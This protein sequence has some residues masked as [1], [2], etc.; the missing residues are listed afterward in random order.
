LN[1]VLEEKFIEYE[2]KKSIFIGYVKPVIS[3]DE[4]HLF[5]DMIKAKHSD[6]THNVYAY[7]IIENGQEIYKACDDGE[8]KNTAG[9]P[10]GEIFN[11]HNL[12]NLVVVI[13]RYFGGIKLGAGGLIRSYAKAAKLAIENSKIIKYEKL[14]FIVI[15]FDYSKLNL[16]DNILIENKIIDIEKN[17]EE[18]ITYRLSVNNDVIAQLKEIHDVVLIEG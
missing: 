5:I 2:I 7:R 15:N 3:K 11:H 10:I 4:A 17:Y 9:K 8:P 6:A 13:T 18:R 12:Y 14:N 1:T 16:I